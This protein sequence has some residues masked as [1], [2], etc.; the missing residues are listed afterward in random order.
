MFTR[1]SPS[2]LLPQCLT[3]SALC[4]LGLAAPAESEAQVIGTFM[5]RTEPY[6]NT[7]TLTVIQEGPVFRLHGTEDLCSNSTTTQQAMPVEGTAVI[8][9]GPNQ[10]VIAVNTFST[11]GGSSRLLGILNLA[12]LIGTWYDDHGSGPLVPATGITRVPGSPRRGGTPNSFTHFVTANNRPPG[13]ADNVS[14][15]SHPLTDGDSLA[16]IVFT[17]NRRSQS[18]IRPVVPST[19][20]LYYDDDGTGLGGNLANNVWCLSRDDNQQMPIEAG[21]NI[22]VLPR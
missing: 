14:C 1:R 10:A 18:V 22:Y 4:L 12:T 20:S 13:G 21:F 3:L 5:W 7:L 11:S 17:P 9:V 8:G 2:S 16:Q 15:F 19:V 6:C